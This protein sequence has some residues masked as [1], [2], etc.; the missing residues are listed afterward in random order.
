MA[1]L[2]SRK[3]GDTSGQSSHEHQRC[4]FFPAMNQQE[5]DQHLKSQPDRQEGKAT[6]NIHGMRWGGVGGFQDHTGWHPV[7]GTAFK[8]LL[9]MRNVALRFF[10]HCCQRAFK[11]SHLFL[12]LLRGLNVGSTRKP[13]IPP[14]GVGGG[15]N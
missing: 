13:G 5:A 7:Q 8:L 15:R 3:P 4:H 11:M 1:I 2:P 6:S 10:P 9:S 14:P 12:L